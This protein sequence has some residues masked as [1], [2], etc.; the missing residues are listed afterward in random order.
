[1]SGAHFLIVAIARR[2]FMLLLERLIQ[3]HTQIE[4]NHLGD[5]RRRSRSGWPMDPRRRPG[6]PRLRCHGAVGDDLRYA[7]AAIALG[8]VVDH[9]VAVFHA[10]V[11]IE[12]GH[13]YTFRIEEA[14]E[15]QVV[16]A[17]GPGR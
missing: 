4:G 6:P 11:D 2:Q 10:E 17:A 14:L 13:G 3:S 16:L 8:H 5:S 7:I 1:M 12:I 9:P 15:Q